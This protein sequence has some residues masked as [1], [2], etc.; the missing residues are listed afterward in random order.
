MNQEIKDKLAKVYQLV[1]QGA[2]EGERA[3]AEKAL[4]RLLKR[5]NLSMEA[6]NEIAFSEYRFKYSSK[7]DMMLMLRLKRF[8]FEE[9]YDKIAKDTRNCKD[10]VLNMTFEDY[11]TLECAYEYFR[12]H[13]NV[14]WK[15]F[16]AP[17]IKKKRTARTRNILR[18]ELQYPFFERYVINSNL[19]KA[20]E[21]TQRQMTEKDE[22][23]ESIL[24]DVEG[25]TYNKQVTNGL[26]LD[27][28]NQAEAGEQGQLQMF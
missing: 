25:G 10:M 17:L 27:K 28:G 18:E 14:Q 1:N 21:V 11:I 9:K 20:E 16:C 22:K 7:L 19:V 24:G 4:E 15:R 6:L 8:F 2:T 12:R 23:R 5:H 26:L 13:M 3:A